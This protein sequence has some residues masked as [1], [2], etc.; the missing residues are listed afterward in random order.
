MNGLSLDIAG[1]AE[2]PVLANLLQFYVHDFSQLFG[3][4]SR[5]DLSDDGRYSIDIPLAD[6]WQAPAH[7]P[8][9]FRL[10]GILAGFALLNAVTHSR[11]P[12]D[13]NIAEF[14]VVRKYRRA[15]LGLAAAQALFTR[16]SGRWEAA[17]MRSN[18]GARNFW[19]HA[20]TRHPALADTHVADHNDSS[21]NGTIF[22]FVISAS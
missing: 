9:L 4:T 19:Q 5:C 6:W 18:T 2:Q 11:L 15:G 21:W 20:I 13:R 16:Y 17:V 1:A 10:D 8:L 14:F 3:G 12:A 7:I 22:R